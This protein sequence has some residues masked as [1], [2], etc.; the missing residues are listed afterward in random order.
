MDNRLDFIKSFKDE[1]LAISEMTG[2][3]AKFRDLD[4]ALRLEAKAASD[5]NNQAMARSVANARTRLE[6][7]CQH[8]IKALCLKHELKE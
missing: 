3:R 4:E 8:A 2:C 6:E 5:Y 7:A 1:D